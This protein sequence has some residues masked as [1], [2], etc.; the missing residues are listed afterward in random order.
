MPKSVSHDDE[1]P[2]NSL[3][4][5]FLVVHRS[6]RWTDLLRLSPDQVAVMG[7]S[8][9]NQI[10]I[11]SGQASRQ[12]A[13]LRWDQGHW[14]VRDL[15]SRNGT[16]VNGQPIRSAVQLR[17]SDRIEAAGCEMTFVVKLSDALASSRSTVPVVPGAIAG[18][19]DDQLTIEHFAE[20]I[21]YQSH[22]SRF[23]EFADLPEGQADGKS[24]SQAP[25]D[26]ENA[27]QD[28]WPQLF[29]L[30][31]RLATHE[32]QTQAAE[33][34]IQSLLS[35]VGGTGGGIYLQA[36]SKQAEGVNDQKSYSLIHFQTID[37]RSYRPPVQPLVMQAMSSG[38]AIIA[39]NVSDDVDFQIADSQG[40]RSVT[41]LL[42]APIM[43]Q[44]SKAVGLECVGYIHLYHADSAAD[45][46][47]QQLDFVIAASRLF[48]VSI[49]NLRTRQRLSHSL[50]QSRKQVEQLRE[51]LSVATHIVGDSPAIAAVKALIARVA[52]SDSTV[53]IRGESGVGKELVATAIHHASRRRDGAMICLNCAAISRSLLESELFG[54]EKGAFTGATDLKRGKFESASGGTLMLDE[55][56]EMDF[57]LQAK[58]LRVLEGHPFERVGGHESIRVNVRL[59][60]ATN[61][62]LQAEV[63]QGRFRS[64]LFYRLNVVE[65][66]VPPLRERLTDI[67]PIA[68]YYLSMFSDKIGRRVDGFTAAACQR[69][70][71]HAWPGNIREL[72]NTIE[73]AVVLGTDRM[74]DADELSLL[75]ASSTAT[76]ASDN[77]AANQVASMPVIKDQV[78]VLT[79]ATPAKAPLTL[80]EVERQYLIEVLR[81]LDGNKSRAAVALG[82]ER[83]TLDRKM[84]RF[85]IQPS[86]YRDMV[87]NKSSS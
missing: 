8:S 15:G 26:D 49:D 82:I 13:E 36:A 87:S 86:D 30:A 11:R 66:V 9:S 37:N 2:E 3:T 59:I 74:I 54:H 79:K 67:V 6:G 65:I 83:S 73:R 84:K 1:L 23:L 76:R 63:A 45:F 32:S 43:S 85:D 14:W 48:A 27:T 55:I 61:R 58:L 22:V 24:V 64:D 41:T 19:T 28:A 56:G 51:Q 60:A 16:L 62:D 69:L 21:T 50:K 7:R 33:E 34:L 81:Q 39:R 12:H 5:A 53:L 47:A 77:V 70:M 75:P 52:G 18:Q 10:V 40:D 4:R 80:D 29:A 72:K 25:Y 78:V 42:V 68:H 57:D 71:E 17:D 31:Y 46:S 20:Q 44:R 35:T 38:Q